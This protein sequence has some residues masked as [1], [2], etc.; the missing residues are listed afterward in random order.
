MYTLKRT[1]STDLDFQK[2]VNQLDQYLAIV[3]GDK[4]DFL[5]NTIK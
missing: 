3:N 2:L 1:N 5:F 4:N